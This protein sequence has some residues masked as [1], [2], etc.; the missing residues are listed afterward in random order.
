MPW[1]VRVA[2]DEHKFEKISHRLAMLMAFSAVAVAVA[3][4]IA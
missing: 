4:F 1:V 3:T 2:R